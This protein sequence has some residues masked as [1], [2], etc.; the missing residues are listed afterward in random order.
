MP[1]TAF[2]GVRI[3]WLIVARNWLFARLDASARAIDRRRSRVRSS[4]RASSSAFFA[5]S[6]RRRC[7]SSHDKPAKSATRPTTTSRPRSLSKRRERSPAS[8]IAFATASERASAE[9]KSSSYR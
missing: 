9:R 2:S 5:T 4:T 8:S 7:P 6:D 3:S 1:I